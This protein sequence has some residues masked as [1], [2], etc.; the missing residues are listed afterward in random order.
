[1]ACGLSQGVQAL[2]LL[3]IYLRPTLRAK[4]HTYNWKWDVSL[5]KEM[6]FLALPTGVGRTI[7]MVAHTLFYQIMIL[8]GEEQLTLSVMIQSFLL[9]VLFC[10][11][12][13]SKGV[14]TVISNL[15]GAKEYQLIPQVIR[16]GFKVHA[17]I[18]LV[19]TLLCF[20]S[21]DFIYPQQGSPLKI[22]LL[23][24]GAF[25]LIDGFSWILS[26]YLTAIGDTKFIMYTNGLGQWLTYLLP[27]YL[28]VVYAGGGAVTGWT[29]LTFNAL[30]LFFIFKWRSKQQYLRVCF[31]QKSF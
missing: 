14:T 24:M 27:I 16:A 9:L 4:F 1:M 10:I 3:F 28:L 30:L 29:V 31:L 15:V 8:A 20:L 19:I 17:L 23:W 5:A 21:C 25:F 2:F 12:G 18:A 7:E 13:L 26:G 11:D 22:G 6:L